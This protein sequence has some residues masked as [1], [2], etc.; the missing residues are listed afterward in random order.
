MIQKMLASAL[1]AGCAAGLL[2]ALLHFAFVQKYILLG[3]TYETGDAVH[4]AAALD[5]HTHAD[6]AA[7]GS[8][9]HAHE[10]TTTAARNVWTVL[11]TGLIYVAYAII[12][13]AGFGL[14]QTF[15]ITIGPLQGLLWG[16]GGFVAFQLAP[17]LGTPPE[18]PG[19]P[20]PDLGDRQVWWWFTVAATATGLAL[21]AYG[22]KVVFVALAVALLAAPHM[23]GAPVLDRFG[24][25]APPEVAAFFAARV[26]GVGMAVWACMGWIAGYVWE[27][28]R[29]ITPSAA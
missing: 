4:F 20:A 5:G 18:L 17:A 13:V 3:E 1:I 14:A 7:H 6:E 16:I 21:L 9:P 28:D 11:F 29:M 2:A 19:T 10:E 15:G 8:A 12:L 25:V 24:G 22:R 26:L 23:I 27:R